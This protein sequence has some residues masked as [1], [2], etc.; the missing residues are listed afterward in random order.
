[1]IKRKLRCKQFQHEKS[2]CKKIFDVTLALSDKNK[3]RNMKEIFFCRCFKYIIVES[4]RRKFT[5]H[6]KHGSF[7]SIWLHPAYC[8]LSITCQKRRWSC[9]SGTMLGPSAGIRRKWVYSTPGK[10]FKT[11]CNILFTFNKYR[12]VH[13]FKDVDGHADSFITSLVYFSH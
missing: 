3:I 6:F 5:F 4:K 8:I 12:F 11:I 2:D 13:S 10:H 9:S 7:N 1:M